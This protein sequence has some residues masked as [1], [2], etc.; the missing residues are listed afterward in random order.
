MRRIHQPGFAD[1]A[2]VS[3]CFSLPSNVPTPA[4]DASPARVVRFRLNGQSRDGASRVSSIGWAR[5][6]S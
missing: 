6:A 1:G 2:K 4:T 3:V 5:K